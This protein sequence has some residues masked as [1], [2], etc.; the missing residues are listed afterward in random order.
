MDKLEQGRPSQCREIERWQRKEGLFQTH[1]LISSATLLSVRE[2]HSEL[3][4]PRSHT[5]ILSFP[6]HRFLVRVSYLELYNEE[7]R[8][9]LNKSVK[10]KLE[11]HVRPDIG[12]Y[13]KDL[14]CF[15]VKNADEMEKLMNI[16]DK[17]SKIWHS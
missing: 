16:G 3:S 15:V 1:L 4:C 6:M 7:V 17:N 12:A 10:K 2:R 5:V 8:D 9:L 13:V 11:I 14:S